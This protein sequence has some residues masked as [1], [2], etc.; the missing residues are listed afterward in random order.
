MCFLIVL[1]SSRASPPPSNTPL[2]IPFYTADDSMYTNLITKVEGSE[3][4]KGSFKA[5]EPHIV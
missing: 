5:G 3:C 1:L 2:Q 4:L